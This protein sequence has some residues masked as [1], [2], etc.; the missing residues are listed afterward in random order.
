MFLPKENDN[1][2]AVL[3]QVHSWSRYD[4]VTHFY[5]RVHVPP[6]FF[7]VFEAFEPKQFLWYGYFK[8]VLTQIVQSDWTNIKMGLKHHHSPPPTKNLLDLF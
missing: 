8:R 6:F 1:P 4:I 2:K 7:F 3:A 5:C